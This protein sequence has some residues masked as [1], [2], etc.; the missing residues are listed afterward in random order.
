MA[1]PIISVSSVPEAPTSAPLMISTLFPSTKPV[2]AAA[3]PVNELSSE[4]MTGISA[5][6]I[7]STNSTP[8]SAAAPTATKNAGTVYWLAMTKPAATTIVSA[9]SALTI[10]WPGIG[11]G[12]ARH[13]LLQLEEGD[14]AAGEADR[15][16]HA[17]EH[18]RDRLIPGDV[19]RVGAQFEE[20]GR[21]DHRRSAAARA[22]EERDHLRH[23]GH[24]HGARR[25]DADRRT[26]A[27]A[28][29]QNPPRA[30]EVEL[31][32]GCDQ[33]DRHAE[34][35]D[36]VAAA[37]G[38]GRTEV[39]Q[40]DDETDARDEVGAVDR[41]RRGRRGIGHGFFVPSGAGETRGLNIASI[42]SVTT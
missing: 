6:P 18:H 34:H 23:R 3:S 8:S 4:M 40:A 16:D 13:E 10:C 24:L 41:E 28:R 42:R 31:E 33:R 27:D 21:S 22:V 1:L 32:A 11:D 25:V 9:T 14:D 7:G 20:L 39:A 15:T 29:Q 30:G 36:P 12:T 37:R 5:P 35:R 38:L 17:R 2:S 26:G 19:R